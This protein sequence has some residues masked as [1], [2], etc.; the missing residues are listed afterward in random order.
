MIVVSNRVT[1]PDERI[2]TFLGRL[3][4]SYG[5]EH[6][7]GFHGMKV[8]APVDA[9][10][11]VTMTFWESLEDYEA[12]RTGGAYDDAHG[13][14]SAEEAFESVNEVEIHEVAIERT[15]TEYQEGDLVERQSRTG[16]GPKLTSCRTNGE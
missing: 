14:T 13:D 6:Q 3:E 5:I 1:V 8:L 10:G 9:E 12:W 4:T 7:P 16:S 15:P 11:H 2:E